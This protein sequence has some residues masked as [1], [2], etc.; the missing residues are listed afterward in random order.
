M[1]KITTSLFVTLMCFSMVVHVT[2]GQEQNLG[3]FIG[4]L[5]QRQAI[6]VQGDAYAASRNTIVIDRFTFNPFEGTDAFFFIG[7]MI[8]SGLIIATEDG[9][10]MP[11]RSYNNERVL[12]RIDDQIITN[13]QVLYIWI[14]S[15]EVNL[16][17]VSIPPGLVL[18]A[19]FSLGPLGLNPVLHN[20]RADNVIIVNAKQLRLVNF[21][22]DDSAPDVYFWVGTGT[23]SGSGQRV[24]DEN[25]VINEPISEYNRETITIT[26][27]DNLTVFDVDYLSVWCERFAVDFGHVMIP[28]N[29]DPLLLPAFLDAEQPEPKVFGNCQVLEEDKLQVAWTVDSQRDVICIQLRGKVDLNEYMAFGISGS[30][31]STLMRG[32]D[33][34]VGWTD[35]S[36]MQGNAVDYFLENY[37]PCSVNQA[38]GACPDILL[39]GT[40]DVTLINHEVRD[41]VTYIT[42]E[43]PITAAVGLMQ[44]DL[45]IPLDRPVFISWAYGRIN[46]IG[47]VT[48]HE[49]RTPGNV[50]INFGMAS[51]TCPDF[52]PETDNEPV[53]PWFIPPIVSLT[54][55]T[56]TAFIGPS[57]GL[58][59]VQG[60]TGV[61]GWGIAWYINNAIIPEITVSRGVQYVFVVNGGNDP[62]TPALN[63]PFYIT[64]SE[65]G[66]YSQL[67]EAQQQLETIYAGPVSG[68]LCEW[69]TTADPI[70][71]PNFITY[72]ATLN[73]ECVVSTGGSGVFRW[74]PDNNTPDLVY[75]QCYTHQYLGWKISVVG[76][77]PIQPCDSQPCQNG[78]ICTNF[79]TTA[80]LC[81]CAGT[82]FT[83][84]QC[85]TGEPSFQPCD[86]QPCVNQGVCTN[87]GPTSFQCNC[88]TG[89]TGE[90]CEIPQILPCDTQPCQNGGTCTNVGTTFQCGCPTGFSGSTCSIPQ[91]LPC[92]MQPCQNDGICSNVGT[93]FQCQCPAGFSGTTCSA[94]VIVPCEL[95][96]CENGAT[97][98]NIG[99]TFQCLCP[100]GFTGVTCQNAPPLPCDMRPCQNGGTCV[101]IVAS[102][103]RC[104]CPDSFTGQ[105][106]QNSPTPSPCDS[107]TCL[108]GGTCT[109]MGN[110]ATCQCTPQ[111]I[112]TF[113]ERMNTVCNFNPCRNGAT[114]V[115]DEMGMPFCICAEGFHGNNCQFLVDGPCNTSPCFNGGICNNIQLNAFQCDCR[116]TSFTGRQCNIPLSL[117]CNSNPC[118][119]G[120]TCRN[121]GSNTGITCF[122][123][124][125][126]TGTT[127]QSKLYIRNHSIIK[128]GMFIIYLVITDVSRPFYNTTPG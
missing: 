119:N 83:G 58:R 17:D 9:S 125:P 93:T 108:N 2:Q 10:T 107:V 75:Y 101:N 40:D 118:L 126:F 71:H 123:E 72:Q 127:C 73:L 109:T 79:G 62:T 7:N 68:P 85:Q 60:I 31:T 1:E 36:T 87:T 122:C 18:P 102:V 50:Q 104:I 12:L 49:T 26:L 24:P 78:G 77:A 115:Q 51:S 97:C 8:G 39:G 112:G 52:T 100:S 22:Y 99:S 3:P 82:G 61:V 46:D 88:P 113:C 28:M 81:N 96:P 74:I 23:P 92:D 120:G 91:I 32:S 29:L 121:T 35:A 55:N 42:Y 89:F 86:F 53:V 21:S 41:G 37:V 110:G 19:E 63:H 33:V 14:P 13:F 48:R 56:F 94:V 43:K 47:L 5:N 70:D 76:E 27:P 103:F 25:G 117:P 116:L 6:I 106:C 69:K 4:T 66:G 84:T 90:R 38:S 95:Q 111:F 65:R 30:P 15:I 124:P 105:R 20:V 128:C 80:F 16:G 59:G 11:L 114:C 45:S 98:V 54:S 44:S 67:T 64:S 34:T 57:G